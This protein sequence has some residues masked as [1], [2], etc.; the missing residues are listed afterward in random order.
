MFRLE[1]LFLMQIAMGIL[2]IVFIQ[3]LSKIKKQ[4][5]EITTEVKNYIS[6]ITEEIQEEV[7]ESHS[8]EEKNNFL[9]K[10]KET[11]PKILTKEE[12]QNSLIQAVLG[13]YF[14]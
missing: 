10:P 14:P 11:T 4:I 6:F 1:W 7:Q 2:M 3:K 9:E 5:D 8:I 13:E 12:A